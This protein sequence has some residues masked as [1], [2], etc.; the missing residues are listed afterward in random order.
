MSNTLKVSSGDVVINAS[1]GRPLT[2]SGSNKLRQDITEFFAVDIRPNGFGSG[3]EQLIGLIE[4]SQDAFITMVDR[5]IRDGVNAIIQLQ[6]EDPRISR[7]NTEKLI[8]VTGIIVERDTTDQTKFYFRVN[9]KTAD[10]KQ[11]S[12][13]NVLQS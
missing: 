2:V 4:I 8:G 1:N 6:N 3:I 13:T 11:F 12:T 10:G 7:D 5:Q 9:F